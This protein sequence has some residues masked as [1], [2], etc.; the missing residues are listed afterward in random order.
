MSLTL[1]PNI[2]P[3]EYGMVITAHDQVGNQTYEAR[4]N[5]SIE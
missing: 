2:R 3:G 4:Q 5:F 1:Q